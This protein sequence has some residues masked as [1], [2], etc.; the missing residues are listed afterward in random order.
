M[1]LPGSLPGNNDAQETAVLV[2]CGGRCSV[3]GNAGGGHALPACVPSR[4][5]HQHAAPAINGRLSCSHLVDG[6]REAAEG[7][8]GLRLAGGAGGGTGSK[9][10]PPPALLPHPLQRRRIY[11][12]ERDPSGEGPTDLE[13]WAEQERAPW[14]NRRAERRLRR[15]PVTVA[16]HQEDVSVIDSGL[17]GGEQIVSVGAPYLAEGMKVTRMRKTE[18]AVPR[19]D[20]PL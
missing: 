5:R 9:S 8:G 15:A 19:E 10:Q 16:F 17:D 6:E 20:D 4:V 18:Q 13:G 7:R 14:P 1:R 2:K 11:P 12:P 3:I